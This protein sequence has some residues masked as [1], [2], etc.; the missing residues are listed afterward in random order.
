MFKSSHIKRQTCSLLL[1]DKHWIKKFWCYPVRIDGAGWEWAQ[2]W[3]KREMLI[4][5][6]CWM[7]SCSNGSSI[8]TT[9]N[10][11]H[12]GKTGNPRFV[13]VRSSNFCALHSH[14]GKYRAE[15]AQNNGGNHECPASYEVTY[16][17]KTKILLL[18]CNHRSLF[19]LCF[20]FV[21]WTTRSMSYW[22]RGQ[23]NT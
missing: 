7:C 11:M 15:K 20:F 1:R 4:I 14:K 17:H 12:T 2:A 3:V 16:R 21:V 23:L 5:L 6:N 10:E 9:K 8:L 19:A 22:P 18:K 13:F